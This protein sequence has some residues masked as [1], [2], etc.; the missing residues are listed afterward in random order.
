M[1]SFIILCLLWSFNCNN[2]QEN[3]CTNCGVISYHST[4]YDSSTNKFENRDLILPARIC[5]K[6]SIIIQ[7]SFSIEFWEYNGNEKGKTTIDHYSYLDLKTR[8]VYDYS[9]FSDT[10]KFIKKYTLPDSVNLSGGWSFW[11][12]G[13]SYFSD[14]SQSL[15]DTT[16]NHVSY[17]RVISKKV[18]TD[19]IRG[20]IS[21]INIGYMRC[22]KKKML[23]H[24]DRTYDDSHDCPIV[25]FE[26]LVTGYPWIKNEI[27]FIK[28]SLSKEE[29]NVF[30]TWEQYA[31]NNPVK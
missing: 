27:E 8:T 11:R 19:S 24:I 1:T 5:Y 10:A 17:Q 18:Y 15:P 20:S 25:R 30:N 14:S 3:Y 22:D 26:Y 23:F 21:Y 9:S 28:E 7:P 16:I 13:L 6:D 12:K 31:K 4:I 29:M 2:P